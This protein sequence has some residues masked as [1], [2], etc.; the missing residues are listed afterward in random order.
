M[1]LKNESIAAIKEL[2]AHFN[3][4]YE[5]LPA[6]KK[7]YYS[8]LKLILNVLAKTSG[9]LNHGFTGK[10]INAGAAIV[11]LD[12]KA[13]IDL[14]PESDLPEKFQAIG[15]GFIQ[16]TAHSVEKEIANL[17]LDFFTVNKDNGILEDIISVSFRFWK[18]IEQILD[19]LVFP[20]VTSNVTEEQLE[21]VKSVFDI[22]LPLATAS[23]DMKLKNGVQ[24]LKENPLLNQ[25]LAQIGA[26]KRTQQVIKLLLDSVIDNILLNRDFPAEQKIKILTQFK[27][28]VLFI[29]YKKLKNQIIQLKQQNQNTRELEIRTAEIFK[30]I[31][32]DKIKSLIELGQASYSPTTR[33]SKESQIKTDLLKA[34]AETELNFKSML[35]NKDGRINPELFRALSIMI[36]AV[37]P[38]I[39][40]FINFS[41]SFPVQ[42]AIN[43]LDKNAAGFVEL[44]LDSI[45]TSKDTSGQLQQAVNLLKQAQQVIKQDIELQQKADQT[46]AQ[47]TQKRVAK[48]QLDRSAKIANIESQ[49]EQLT[50]RHHQ[51]VSDKKSEITR[52]ELAV[53]QL[54]QDI[55][56]YKNAL[57]AD[58]LIYVV[59]ERLATRNN[60][61]PN[62][63]P[64]AKRN[65]DLLRDEYNT[66]ITKVNAIKNL[67]TKDVQD[68]IAIKELCDKSLVDL[69]HLIKYIES[70]GTI[71][72]S[73]AQ[74]IHVQQNREIISAQPNCYKGKTEKEKLDEL[75]RLFFERKLGPD[76]GDKKL[77]GAR[78]LSIK[79]DKDFKLIANLEAVRHQ[80]NS[81][82][83]TIESNQEELTRLT[84]QQTR[85]QHELQ[86]LEYNPVY[87]EELSSLEEQL[88][89][90]KNRPVTVV[91]VTPNKI[92]LQTPTVNQFRARACELVKQYDA[93][94]TSRC[95]AEQKATAAA[96]E[97]GE[98]QDD[99]PKTKQNGSK[100]LEI[101]KVAL[102]FTANIITLP[103]VLIG[104]LISKVF[105]SIKK[106]VTG[107][108]DYSREIDANII[109][110]AVRMAIREE[111]GE[112]SPT[113]SDGSPTS[114]PAATASA[115]ASHSPV[116]PLFD[117]SKK[118]SGCPSPTDASATAAASLSAKK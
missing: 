16:G 27:N 56:N 86:A 30:A 13:F 53:I 26:D 113:T 104:K 35:F 50:F 85:L 8:K 41:N 67:P 77:G 51:N 108:K 106:I 31:N 81:L 58:E 33:S 46:A 110:R 74:K 5:Q 68:T 102:S 48:A 28:I 11:A 29:E 100:S 75:S 60:N 72:Y 52:T 40:E 25:L 64:N 1:K 44:D 3:S 118:R 93:S 116:T 34:A 79:E 115:N 95:E 101:A 70:D 117:S 112:T 66:I 20:I 49:I 69:E 97:Q 87:Q 71:G 4:L 21:I 88:A 54:R 38:S 96:A 2:V 99:S 47:E 36:A 73:A 57:S 19:G 65:A 32:E 103:F 84:Q 12:T 94:E 18:N 61:N 114:S 39:K 105:Y 10:I 78:L 91:A 14:L 90:E 92:T 23:D 80:L 98:Q 7:P 17:F 43:L 76:F 62:T 109:A 6:Y 111:K 55:N 15:N 59:T 82:K 107:Q 42:E 83:D 89:A 63:Y 24:R 45:D 37:T 9:L 22:V